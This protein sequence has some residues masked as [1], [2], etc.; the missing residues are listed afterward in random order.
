MSISWREELS[1]GNPQIDQQHQELL[2]RF[3]NLLVACRKGEGKLELVRLIG[4]LDEYVVRHFGDEELFQKE[5]GF[6]DYPSHQLQH[7]GFVKRLSE[8]KRTIRDE[9]EVQLDHVLTT[10][11]LLLDWLVQHISTSDRE[12]GTFLREKGVH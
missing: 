9:G 8:L 12:L 1:I 10:N 5:H 2:E 7:L 3:D 4:F 6:P 11:K